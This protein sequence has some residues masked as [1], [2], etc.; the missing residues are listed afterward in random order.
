[1]LEGIL[2]EGDPLLVAT[3]ALEKKGLARD[4]PMSKLKLLHISALS[5]ATEYQREHTPEISLA[6]ILVYVPLGLRPPL[7]T[8]DEYRSKNIIGQLVYSRPTIPLACKFSMNFLQTLRHRPDEAFE[9]FESDV[10]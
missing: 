7:A 4:M 10:V 5:M 6:D 8:E 1:M 2:C 9:S 3:A